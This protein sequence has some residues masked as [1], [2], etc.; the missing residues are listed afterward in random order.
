MPDDRETQRA[1]SDRGGKLIARLPALRDALEASEVT[2]D[3]EKITAD[4]QILGDD[5]DKLADDVRGWL[6]DPPAEL[7]DASRPPYAEQGAP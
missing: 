6:G 3:L 2:A 5:F 1:L 4:F 7:P